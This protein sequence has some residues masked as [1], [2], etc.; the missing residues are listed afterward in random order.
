MIHYAGANVVGSNPVSYPRWRGSLSVDFNSGPFGVAIS[1]QYVGKMGRFL[2][3]A[4]PL[5]SNFVNPGVKAFVY[6]DLTLTYTVPQGEGKFEFFTTINNLF[7]KN[8]PIIPGLT[9]GVNLPTNI[10][11]YDVIGRSVT[12]GV[13]VKF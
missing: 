4:A 13:R 12:A 6:T 8:P 11:T 2:N 9:P 7:D 3:A 1:E 5:L 10:S